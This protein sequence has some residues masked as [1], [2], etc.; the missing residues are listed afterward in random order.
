[1]PQHQATLW[2]TETV[3][4]MVQQDGRVDGGNYSGRN[5]DGALFS[6]LP[7]SFLGYPLHSK[8]HATHFLLIL[9]MVT[10]V[11]GHWHWV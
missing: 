1:M 8:S 6:R 3:M 7:W 11:R 9:F 4:D 5:G 10:I 2:S